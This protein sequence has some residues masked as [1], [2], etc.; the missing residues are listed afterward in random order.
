MKS[1]FET[2]FCKKVVLKPSFQNVRKNY[3]GS[4]I[5]RIY[6]WQLVCSQLSYY[7]VTAVQIDSSFVYYLS[8]LMIETEFIVS[9]LKK[10]A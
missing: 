1:C 9:A 6:I 3:H 10:R 7:L 5:I 4:E 2:T 8:I